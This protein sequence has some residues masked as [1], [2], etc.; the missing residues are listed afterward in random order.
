M[1]VICPFS[2]KNMVKLIVAST[3]DSNKQRVL[4]HISHEYNGYRPTDGCAYMFTRLIDI[5]SIR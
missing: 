2:M 3:C 1:K 4:V 5:E